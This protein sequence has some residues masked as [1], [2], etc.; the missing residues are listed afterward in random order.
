MQNIYGLTFFLYCLYEMSDK[1]QFF[2][3][4]CE[5]LYY[6]FYYTSP[7]EAMLK[8]VI[9]QT[10]IHSF[11]NSRK[12]GAGDVIYYCK[13]MSGMALDGVTLFLHLKDVTNTCKPMRHCPTIGRNSSVQWRKIGRN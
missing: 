11:E 6:L 9:Y 12:T 13:M 7:I 5:I 10:I 2:Y 1:H 3:E 8:N 4:N